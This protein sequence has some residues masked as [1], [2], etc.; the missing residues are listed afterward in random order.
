MPEPTAPSGS[1]KRMGTYS[2]FALVALL[3]A[4][5]LFGVWPRLQAG[6]AIAEIQ[7]DTRPNVMVVPAQRA[8]ASLELTLPGTLL[9]IQEAL[10]YARTN[11]YVKQWLVDIGA[12][13]KQGQLLAEIETPEIDRELKQALANQQQVKANM[14]LARSTAERWKA[15]LKENAVSPQEVDEKLSAVK[16]RQAD[17]A[18]SQASVERL[19]QMKSFQRVNAP[20]AGA[21]TGRNVEIGQLI[22]ATNTDP[23][24][25]M[26]KVAKTDTLK[27][28]INVPQSHIRMI[29]IGMPVN[30]MLKEFPTPFTGKV[31]RTAGALDSQSKTLLTEINLPNDKAELTAGMFTQV[32]FVLNQTEPSILLPSNT[33]MVRQDG[34]QVAAIANNAVQLRKVKLGRDFGTQIEILSGVNEKDMIVTNPTDAMR[35]GV[36]VNMKV[37]EP[38]KPAAS[39]VAKPEDTPAAPKPIT[40]PAAKAS[41]NIVETKVK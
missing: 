1:R 15:V 40:K 4:F 9:P 11:G 26:F 23:N 35:D 12:Q 19:I 27:L 18:A 22:S 13:V 31:L 41:E 14:E 2:A 25:W 17:Y 29:K 38:E 37:T 6:K 24:R 5:F 8:K 34:P 39:P 30:V 36:S 7:K 32:K 28:Y 21:I 16:A 33:L 10:I 3:G 20:F